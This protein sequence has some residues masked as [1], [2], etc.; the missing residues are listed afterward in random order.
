MCSLFP[1]YLVPGTKLPSDIDGEP[2][3]WS[4]SLQ[5][6]VDDQG[7][8]A[9]PS[10]EMSAEFQLTAAT[11]KR[12]YTFKVRMLGAGCRWVVGYTRVPDITHNLFVAN[13]LH[14]ALKAE[15]NVFEPLNSNY[16][17]LFASA[18]YSRSVA[19]ATVL[20]QA[21]RLFR[22]ADHGFGILATPLD[23]EGRVSRPGE[24]LYFETKDLVHYEEKGII[25][26]TTK[27]DLLDYSCELEAGTQLYRIGWREADGQTR[28]VTTKDFIRFE[29]P[30]PGE[31]FPAQFMNLDIR[32]AQPGAQVI[33]LTASEA[34]YL[35]NKLGRVSNVFVEAPTITVQAGTDTLSLDS[36]RVTARY[37]D[38]S[39]SLKRVKV[40]PNDIAAL[41]LS[42]QGMHILRAKVVRHRFPYPM[43]KVRPDPAI[44]RYKGQYYFISTD[45]D[46]QRK[47]YIRSAD[48]L[49]GLEDGLTDEVLLWNGEIPDGERR[50][51]HWAPELH[52]IDGKLY[53]LLA[54]SVNDHWLG[55]QAHLV[56]LKGDDP[57][58]PSHWDTPRR[59][60]DRHGKVLADPNDRASSF[61]LDMT[62][63]ENN[64]KA[65]VVW[66]QS[67]WF[68]EE[69]ERASL[70]I[71]T[72]DP[73][74]PWQ[75]TSDPVRIC[76]N[77]YGWDR[78]GD[79][80]SGVAEGAFVLKR[81]DKIYQVYSGSNVGP[82]YAVGLLEMF[83]AD[84]PL[85][86][87]AWRK[88]NYPVMHSLSL[89]GQ[90]GPG[91]NM[92]VQDEYGD[93]YNVYHACG[94]EGG[95]RHGS[96]RPMHFRIDGTPILDMREEEELRPEFEQVNLTIVVR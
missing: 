35:R 86:P 44:L 3:A 80:A 83:A 50:G 72:I 77:E 38:G 63:F 26:L 14:L 65:Y 94:I 12:K 33:A 32:G 34:S 21:P 55:V 48:T 8:L 75:L 43:M 42:Q 73:A 88:F 60:L 19:G 61:S 59:V 91:H 1:Y 87:A 52:V 47:I 57:M 69:Q 6:S 17:I 10:E 45:D 16:G 24:L 82:H 46:G 28:Y 36:I 11:S 7:T 25:K 74:L 22:L 30:Q 51:Q 68:G 96:I 92:F 93:W 29:S 4:S 70:Y 58:N 15:G 81:N 2:A 90:Y 84:D 64:G 56:L 20:L 13:S 53:C 39:I 95:F 62:Y 41:N 85:D 66:S 37:S 5:G 31:M 71:A 27:S 40:D 79:V 18:D 76:R 54:I 67:K 78:N 23:Y 89:P 9:F 49:E